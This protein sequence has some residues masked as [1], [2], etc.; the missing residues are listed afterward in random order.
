MTVFV[1]GNNNPFNVMT[2]NWKTTFYSLFPN[3]FKVLK[4]VLGYVRLK[5]RF[6]EKNDI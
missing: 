1:A 2:Y 5:T 3:V 6:Y 4:T